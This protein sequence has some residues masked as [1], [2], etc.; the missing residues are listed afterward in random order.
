LAEQPAS[1]ASPEASR[2]AAA[3]V[4]KTAARNIETQAI[5]AQAAEIESRAERLAVQLETTRTTG[6]AIAHVAAFTA[7]VATVTAL[8]AMLNELPDAVDA[9]S[10]AVPA[11]ARPA[12][13]PNR[14][15]Q[16]LAMPY[17]SF[18]SRS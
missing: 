18:A 9:A 8:T 6:E 15:R 14:S 7:E 17:F 12:R 10:T 3:P 4:R 16:P 11:V 2:F 13:K 1:Q 5:Q